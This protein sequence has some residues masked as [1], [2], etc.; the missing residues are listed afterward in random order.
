MPHWLDPGGHEFEVRTYEGA[1]VIDD[2]AD[3]VE[4]DLFRILQECV[5]AEVDDV[6]GGGKMQGGCERVLAL[7]EAIPVVRVPAI[8]DIPT[9]QRQGV[10][11]PCLQPIIACS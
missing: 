6:P 1:A 9:S 11:T 8:S 2:F 4:P 7:P 10:A 3:A 5:H